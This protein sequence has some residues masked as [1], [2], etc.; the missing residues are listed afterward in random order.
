MQDSDRIKSE[1]FITQEVISMKK[2]IAAMA[3][4]SAVLAI[5]NT[6]KAEVINLNEKHG[7]SAEWYGTLT[8]DSD[9]KTMLMED[10]GLTRDIWSVPTTCEMYDYETLVLKGD[11]RSHTAMFGNV[12]SSTVPFLFLPGVEYNFSLGGKGSFKWYYRPED[13]EALLAA[14]GISDRVDH[15]ENNHYVFKR[16]P[17]VSDENPLYDAVKLTGDMFEFPESIKKSEVLSSDFDINTIV[18]LKS[19]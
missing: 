5:P 16:E 7:V 12:N 9:T 8:Y 13:K 4:A 6:T 18:H 2:L 17:L 10:T 19:E 11:A 3:L 14:E 15:I 1:D